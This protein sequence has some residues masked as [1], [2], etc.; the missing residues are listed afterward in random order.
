MW[1]A[2]ATAP[3]QAGNRIVTTAFRRYRAGRATQATMVLA[4]LPDS[5]FNARLAMWHRCRIGCGHG[6]GSGG[7]SP[8]PLPSSSPSQAVA[9]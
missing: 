7:E 3:S 4:P 2:A 1:A 8:S 6:Y 5:H 9:R